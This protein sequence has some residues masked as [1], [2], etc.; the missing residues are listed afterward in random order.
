[1]SVDYACPHENVHNEAAASRLTC[2]YTWGAT[3]VG[4]FICIQVAVQV[5]Q[6]EAETERGG[7]GEGWVKW[8]N[9]PTMLERETNVATSRLVALEFFPIAVEQRLGRFDWTNLDS[10][11]S[12]KIGW[13]N[14][15]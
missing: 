5:G 1:M 6:T 13:K 11:I 12:A 3:T 8:W 15:I 2:S 7:G 14:A 9:F 10:W 4:W